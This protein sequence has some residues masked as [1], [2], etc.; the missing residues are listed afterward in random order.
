MVTFILNNQLL[1]SDK[2]TG[3][4]LL[5]FIRYQEDL[6]GTK[7][8][9]REGD[10]G[11]CT[12]LEGTLNKSTVVYK[13]IVSCLT[14]LGNV[15]GK[16]IVTIEGINM[17]HLSPVQKAIVDNSSTQCGFCTPG[18]VMSFTAHTLS[19]EQ[20]VKLKAI[21]SV[22]G[23][24]CRCTGYKSIEKAAEDISG[25]LKDKSI[26]DPV[27]WLV[28]KK[29]LPGYFLTIPERLFGIEK[30]KYSSDRNN[31]IIAGGTDL[32][33]QRADELAEEN[34]SPLQGKKELKG[35]KLKNGKCIIGAT[36]TASEIEYSSVIREIIPEISSYFRL[37]ASEPVRNMGTIAGNIVN[38]SPVGDLTIVF[39]ALNAD[40]IIDGPG[41]V[42]TI[43]LKDLFHGYKKLSIN[44]DE[45]VK[46]V[47]F[48][49]PAK[50][51]LFNF[52]KVSKRTHLDIASVNSAIRIIM[53]GEKVK[54][55]YLSAGGVSPIPLFLT[56]TCNFLKD[57]TIT[58]DIILQANTIM[59][60]EISPI[61]DIRG[62]REYKRLL[63]RQLFFAHFLKLIP[64]RISASDLLQYNYMK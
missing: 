24:I 47:T 27:N 13:S 3:T 20:S 58:P 6:P 23:N 11:A 31:P 19:S 30:R 46:S 33:V 22:S 29:F 2:P 14:P 54:E 9:C 41:G 51:F 56:K 17:E 49:L 59:Q 39:L 21:A 40:V 63:L 57:K 18:F 36:A 28:Q 53:E 61:S 5:D 64:E 10:C 52:E 38:A 43:L 26:D 25:L 15:H 32:M 37:I 16:H 48:P 12:V 4:T 44:K 60:G 45:F 7:I 42:R 1:S 55:C 35:I 50:P 62:S 34:I 8:G